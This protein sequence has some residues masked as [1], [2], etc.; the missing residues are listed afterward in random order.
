M[1]GGEGGGVGLRGMKVLCD[2][3]EDLFGMG[4]YIDSEG[5]FVEFIAA[6]LVVS[7]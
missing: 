3:V 2:V 4:V 7:S 6:M 1:E 5:R